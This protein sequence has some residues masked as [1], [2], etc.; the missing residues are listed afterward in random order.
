MIESM[1]R[2]P[3]L[4]SP[5]GQRTNMDDFRERVNMELKLTL[6]E[7]LRNLIIFVGVVH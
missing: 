7:H 1:D 3:K 5:T 6:S 4:W 2:P